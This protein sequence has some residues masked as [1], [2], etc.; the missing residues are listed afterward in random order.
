MKN[1]TR[2][3]IPGLGIFACAACCSLPILGSFTSVSLLLTLAG[4]I[5]SLAGLLIGLAVI[6]T[7]IQF[8][9]KM[10]ASAC[11]TD[12]NCKS[13]PCGAGQASAN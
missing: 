13:K 6:S 7:V 9:R 8:R 11:S 1:R 10:T 5:K 3:W 2:I 4:G 12:C